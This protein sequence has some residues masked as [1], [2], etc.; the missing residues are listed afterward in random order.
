MDIQWEF[1]RTQYRCGLSDISPAISIYLR[2]DRI[3]HRSRFVKSLIKQGADVNNLHRDGYT[4]LML[5][6]WEMLL[7][8]KYQ[9]GRP[10]SCED[11]KIINVLIDNGACVNVHD[12]QKGWTPLLVACTIENNSHTIRKIIRAGAM[13][14]DSDMKGWTPLMRYCLLEKLDIGIIRLFL[15]KGA[16]PNVKNNKNGSSALMVFSRRRVVDEDIL[17]VFLEYGADI[18]SKNVKG[19][20]CSDRLGEKM[21][22]QWRWTHSGRKSFMMCRNRIASSGYEEDNSFSRSIYSVNDDVFYRICNFL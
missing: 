8:T 1:S 10:V 17:G 2:K 12:P 21:G 13:T 22:K 14:N 19:V 18:N 15:E 16:D 11:V 4:P 6:S 9:C 7:A 20:S 5:S 3:Q